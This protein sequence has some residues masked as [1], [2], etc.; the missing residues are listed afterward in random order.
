MNTTASDASDNIFQAF[1]QLSG[2]IQTFLNRLEY[3]ESPPSPDSM[4]LLGETLSELCHT[5]EML[6]ET[7]HEKENVCALQEYKLAEKSEE[8]ELMSIE[9]AALQTKLSAAGKKA[10]KLN[11][12][13]SE[14][15]VVQRRR[16]TKHMDNQ[17]DMG[18]DS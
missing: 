18:F 14:N 10:E 12:Q 9:I 11:A 2:N 15:G 3:N 4:K 6:T 7:L 1:H 8:C 13:S 5:M 17:L 16:H